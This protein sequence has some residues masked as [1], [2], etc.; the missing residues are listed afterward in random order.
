MKKLL[1]V[2]VLGLASVTANAAGTYQLTVVNAYNPFSP[3][4]DPNSPSF[5]V[6]DLRLTPQVDM[7]RFRNRRELLRGVGTAGER[8]L[9]SRNLLGSVQPEP[10]LLGLGR[11]TP[12]YGCAVVKKTVAEWQRVNWR[13]QIGRCNQI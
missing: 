9:A 3:G 4:N 10:L 6:R 12:G 5:E 2:A 13:E 1:A 7:G 8:V 11:A